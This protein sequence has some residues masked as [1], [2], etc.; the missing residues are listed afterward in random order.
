[1]AS[2]IETTS[3]TTTLKN[4]GNTYATVDT[5]DDVT[6]TNDLAVSGTLNTTGL[7]TSTAASGEN[8]LTVKADAASQQAS[9]SLQVQAGTP[10]QTV[11]Y[12]GKVGATTNGQVGY[13]P[14]NDKMTFFTNNSEK[15]AIDT[16][17]NVGI[18]TTSPDL[19][20]EIV[21]TSSGASKDGLLL[22][23]Y[24]AASNTETGIFFSPTEADG[25]IRGA[26]ISALNDGAAD[27]NSV[28]LKFSTGL[29]A[30]PVE[31]MRIT[32]AG[33]VGIGTS[34]P[35]T[36]YGGAISNVKLALRGAGAGGNNGTATLL[37]GGDNNHYSSITSEH[38]GGGLTYLSF[39]TSPN[40][41]NPTEKMRIAA[42]GNTTFYEG[43]VTQ[44]RAGN[45]ELMS[46]NT[47]GTVKGG[48]QCLS[49]ATVRLGSTSNHPT[50][51]VQ[52]NTVRMIVHTNGNVTPGSDN[53]NELG[54]AS[55]RWTAVYATNGSIQTSD[56][57][58]KT[59]VRKFTDNEIAAAKDLSKEIGMFQWLEAIE[60]KGKDKAR[61]HVGFTVQKAIEIMEGHDLDPMAYGFI[62]YNE[63]ED[64]FVDTEVDGKEKR[65]Q[66]LKAGDRYSFRQDQ[67]N[68]FIARGI[69]AR[70]AKLEGSK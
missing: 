18:G 63:W 46:L 8:K 51:I 48:I 50:E 43:Q 19:K 33:S 36:G 9:L 70:I 21:D 11:M 66:K 59:D 38:T 47:T 58:E 61:Q 14:N 67:L 17:G 40:A 15:M 24:G 34:T 6:I 42:N 32:S 53:S 10:G 27:S 26:R 68:L 65:V 28:A 56:A 23:N 7:I 39:G 29:G 41:G 69:E 12:M 49:N 45:T 4:N 55:Y 44:S 31:R 64:E 16:S 62:C 13:N 60:K 57:R 1:M 25:A 35:S 22:T 3:T 54:G 52:Q 20:M 30:P 5:N 2:S 37:V